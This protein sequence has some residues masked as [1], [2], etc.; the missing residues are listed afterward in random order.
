MKKLF[1][2]FLVFTLILTVPMFYNNY[3]EENTNGLTQVKKP[4]YRFSLIVPLSDNRYWRIL[5]DGVK[6][7]GK[8]FNVD[9]KCVGS[10]HLN[11]EEQIE[12][13]R[14]AI[15][16]N[17]DGIITAACESGEFNQTVKDAR[18]HGIPVLLVD[19]DSPSSNRNMYIGTDNLKAGREVGEAM[20]KATGGKAKIG[21]LVSLADEVNQRERVAG[22][23]SVIGSYPD[24]EVITVAEG[25]SDLPL[26][27]ERVNRMFDQY[28]EI[29]AMFCTEGFGPVGTGGVIR[30]RGLNGRVTVIGFDDLSETLGYVKDKTFYA[31]VVQ[32]Q[33]QM[34]YLAVENLIKYCRGQTVQNSVIDTGVEIVTKDNINTYMNQK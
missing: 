7:A 1:A 23:K 15:A 26:I 2:I 14:A 34:G 4:E 6:E 5:E 16:S 13:I 11:T 32:R 10:S 24:M 25:K 8:K 9:T 33:K 20:V 17:V 31:T 21:I 12:F 22:F 30:S 3:I 27:N 19:S 28:P 29:N 18:N